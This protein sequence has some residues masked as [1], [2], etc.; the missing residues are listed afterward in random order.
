M[1]CERRHAIRTSYDGLRYSRARTTAKTKRDL[2][3]A[4]AIVKRTLDIIAWFKPKYYFIENPATGMLKDRRVVAGIPK[5]TLDYCKYGTPYRKR[6]HLWGQPPASFIPKICC[7]DCAACD[8]I[9]RKHPKSAQRGD[10]WTVHQLH[11][12]PESLCDDLAGRCTVDIDVGA[13]KRGEW[14]Y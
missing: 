14:P 13:V 5:I 7:Y 3:G 6:T 10:G 12:I 1:D 4:D 2:Q 8:K 9:A 11:R